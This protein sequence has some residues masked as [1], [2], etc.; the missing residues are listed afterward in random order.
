MPNTLQ[1]RFPLLPS[2]PFD[3]VEYWKEFESIIQYELAFL[4]N[5]SR[6]GVDP[7]FMK[8]VDNDIWIIDDTTTYADSSLPL[9]SQARGSYIPCQIESG[10]K[11]LSPGL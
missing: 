8:K 10:A 6:S 3:S 9:N 2:E 11:F 4:R 5:Q 7:D 1:H